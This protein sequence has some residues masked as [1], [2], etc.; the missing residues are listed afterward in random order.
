MG[1][2]TAGLVVAGVAAGL[3]SARLVHQPSATTL[4]TAPLPV[5][6]QTVEATSDEA[7]GRPIASRIQAVKDEIAALRAADAA[8]ISQHNRLSVQNVVDQIRQSDAYSLGA[9]GFTAQR[10]EALKARA[11]ELIAERRRAQEASGN[12]G[13]PADRSVMMA[14]LEAVSDGD[15][16]LLPEIGEAEFQRYRTARGQSIGVQVAAVPAG[17][18][19]ERAGIQPG[20][21]ILSYGGKRVIDSA[22]LGMYSQQT[23][24][25]SGVSVELLRDGQRMRL[26]APS[27]PINI[28]ARQR[29]KSF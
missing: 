20:D 12:S 16:L 26:S 17:S 13:A 21:E 10:V 5:A 9:A 7:S 8:I 4:P 25:S 29:V 1:W 14:Y 3:I 23:P 28:E 11:G 24:P 19:A 27:G 6:S 18:N 15:I 22:V 2:K